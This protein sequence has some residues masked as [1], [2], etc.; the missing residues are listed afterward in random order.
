V[1]PRFGCNR[2]ATPDIV[3]RIASGIRL[4]AAMMLSVPSSGWMRGRTGVLHLVQAPD[5]LVNPLQFV[6][7]LVVRDV[8][9]PRRSSQP[10]ARSP[11]HARQ[12]GGTTPAIQQ[13]FE[14]PVDAARPQPNRVPAQSMLHAPRTYLAI[15]TPPTQ[16][17]GNRMTA[18][19]AGP[20]PRW[21]WPT[22]CCLNRA[23]RLSSS[24][25]IDR[26]RGPIN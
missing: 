5:R 11:D 1:N 21:F 22:S 10:S 6:V 2:I 15:P 4:W 26:W 13:S 20:D 17:L 23:V 7:E 12:D 9:D 24:C 18:A 16:T 25:W 8:L 19:N 14:L 3:F